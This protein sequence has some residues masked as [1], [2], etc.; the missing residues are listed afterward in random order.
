MPVQTHFDART[1]ELGIWYAIGVANAFSAKSIIENE[2]H[3]LSS[4]PAITKTERTAI[5]A[6]LMRQNASP[7]DIDEVI[8][9]IQSARLLV[10][11]MPWITISSKRYNNIRL[12][13]LDAH[14]EATSAVPAPWPP[15]SQSVT[16][17]LGD[18]FWNAAL[19]KLGLEEGRRREVYRRKFSDD[20]YLQAIEDFILVCIRG[21]KFPSARRYEKR[22]QFAKWGYPSLASVRSYFGSWDSA[23]SSS[24]AFINSQLFFDLKVGRKKSP[25]D[26]GNRQL[27]EIYDWLEDD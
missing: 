26:F 24:P 8:S 5:A 20:D 22:Q 11:E 4:F 17:H 1:T 9:A 14:P 10:E 16:K 21:G 15:N 19:R 12:S 25:K 18:G 13:Y 3:D 2:G 27:E 23:I 6:I 7:Q